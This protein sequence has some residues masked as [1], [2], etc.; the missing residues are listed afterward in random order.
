VVTENEE[1]YVESDK[2]RLRNGSSKEGGKALIE[3]SMQSDSQSMQIDTTKAAIMR[4]Q[5]ISRHVSTSEI[6][7]HFLLAEP[8]SQ[9]CREQ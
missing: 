4:E 3:D 6:N 5:P 2:K 1:D 9:A 8:G 7:D